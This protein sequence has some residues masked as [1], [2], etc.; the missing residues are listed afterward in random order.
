[1]N[2]NWMKRRSAKT[3][4]SKRGITYEGSQWVRPVWLR[5]RSRVRWLEMSQFM[6]SLEG[7]GMIFYFILKIIDL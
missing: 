6:Q 3:E 4:Q 1:M 5:V 2:S 7:H